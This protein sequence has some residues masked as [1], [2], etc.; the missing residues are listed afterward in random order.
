MIGRTPDAA[1]RVIGMNNRVWIYLLLAALWGLA[2]TACETMLPPAVSGVTV[3]PTL[4]AETVSAR[5]TEAYT[6]QPTLAAT[7]TPPPTA[8]SQAPTATLQPAETLASPAASPSP[9]QVCNRAAAGFP[10]IDVTI[11]DNTPVQPGQ[12]FTKI[13]RLENVGS[14]PWSR[15]YAVRFSHGDRMGAVESVALLGEVAP[16]E[17]VEIAV[18]MVAPLTSGTYRGN[19]KL[20]AP[21]GTLFGIGPM[22]D[23]PFWV[24][25]VVIAPATATA[26]LTPLPT[27]SPTPTQSPTVT[28]TPTL[29]PQILVTAL[30]NLLPGDSL[31]L[32]SAQ[33]GPGD[34]LYEQ[35]TDGFHQIWPQTGAVLGIY[36][37]SQPSLQACRAAGMSAAPIALESLTTGTYLCYRTDQN[38][39]GWLLYNRLNSADGSAQFDLLTWAETP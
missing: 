23:S 19:W 21:D 13:W 22:G 37:A 24:Q 7:P 39:T 4:V 2:L 20:S 9:T 11:D 26:S 28:A 32:D 25:I 27:L 5:Q 3:D 31:E 14:C 16:G 38:R 18:D 6:P 10:K 30:I 33:I 34:M 12:A 29:T 1:Q 17:S 36:G 35:S 15:Q 8:H